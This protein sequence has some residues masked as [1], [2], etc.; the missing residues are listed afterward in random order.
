MTINGSFAGYSG[1][2]R[3]L[4]GLCLGGTGR[5]TFEVGLPAFGLSSIVSQEMARSSYSRRPQ[6]S[7]IQAGKFGTVINSSPNQVK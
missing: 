3:G 7:Q 1:R 4:S 5:F 6:T 2:G